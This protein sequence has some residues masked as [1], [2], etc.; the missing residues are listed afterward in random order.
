MPKHLLRKLLV[1]ALEAIDNGECDDIT[2]E[3]FEIISR[4][5]HSP[6]TMGREDAAKFMQVSLCRFHELKTLGII[7]EP[8]KVKGQ[9]E[10]LYYTSDLHKALKIKKERGL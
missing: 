10:K 3:E 8:R 6:K 5:I 2:D 7:P 1:Q 4:I 9:K